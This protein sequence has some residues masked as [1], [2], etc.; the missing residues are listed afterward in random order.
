MSNEF[1]AQ[2]GFLTIAKALKSPAESVA[3]A[4]QALASTTRR[5]LL[6]LDNADDPR[7]DYTAYFPSGNR[8]AVL[9]TSR[10]PECRKYSTAKSEALEGLDLVHSTQL[11]LK[12][13]Q[14]PEESWASCTAQAQDIVRLLG[15]HTLALIQAGAYIAEGYCRLG[16]YP[17]RY[18][19]QRRQLL[20]WL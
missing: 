1:T 4:L 6:I 10:I 17:K 18:L 11:L 8:G 19:Q 2:N 9:M 14:V 15:S 5:W 16:Q 12:A 20:K 3:E 7:F 13:A